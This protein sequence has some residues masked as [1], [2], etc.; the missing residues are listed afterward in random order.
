MK[1]QIITYNPGEGV[2]EKREYSRKAEAIQDA[3]RRCY[4]NASGSGT[5]RGVIVYDRKAQ[6]VIF[7]IGDFPASFQPIPA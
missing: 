4:F 1:Y 6:Q 2:D 5:D 7:R 3:R